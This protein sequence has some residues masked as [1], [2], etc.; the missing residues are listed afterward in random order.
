MNVWRVWRW[1]SLTLAWRG[2]GTKPPRWAL[3]EPTPGW[4]LRSLSHPPSPRAATSGGEC[5]CVCVCVCVD[6]ASCRLSSGRTAF[7]LY[8]LSIEVN[9]CFIAFEAGSLYI[10][11]YM[12]GCM[13]HTAPVSM[14]GQKWMRRCIGDL[15]LI[16]LWLSLI[17][18]W[19]II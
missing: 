17:N 16:S 10:N 13:S 11:V 15:L 4:P 1:R 7:F 8:S 5:L 3:L 2:S 6:T 18:C 12:C 14:C 19:C 9:R